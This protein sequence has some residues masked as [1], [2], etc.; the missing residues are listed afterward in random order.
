MNQVANLKSLQTMLTEAKTIPVHF[1]D[2]YESLRK[3]SADSQALVD[4]I[5]ATFTKVTKTRI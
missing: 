1:E 5:Y 3:R 4:K 2:L